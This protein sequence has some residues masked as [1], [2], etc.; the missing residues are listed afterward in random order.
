ML[1]AHLC[2]M[3]AW[4]QVDSLQNAVIGIKVGSDDLRE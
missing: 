2:W 1:A 3:M 4:Q